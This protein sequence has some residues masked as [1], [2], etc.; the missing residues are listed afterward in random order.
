MAGLLGDHGHRLDRRRPGADHADAQAGEIDR[1]MRPVAGVVDLALEVR[2]ALDIRHPRIRQAAGGEHDVFRRHR[3]AVGGGHRPPIGAFVERHPIDA[4]IELDVAAQ[5]K[6]VGD[7]VGVFQNFRLR[8]V[9][10]APVPFLLQFVGERI[11][12]LHAFDV[13]ARTG[14]AVPVPGAADIAALLIDPHRQ[15]HARAACAAC[16]FRQSPRRPRRH[17]RSRCLRRGFCRKWMARRTSIRAPSD[18][19]RVATSILPAAQK[20]K[21]QKCRPRKAS[22]H[23]CHTRE[24]G[25]SSLAYD[26]R[27]ARITGHPLEPSSGSPKARPG[28]G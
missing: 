4:G 21:R 19:S 6:P 15:S 1:L 12:I 27:T 25:M 22:R 2:E 28:G 10:L 18:F 9:A 11:G 20:R 14:I 26:A 16:T 7:M 8:R 17:H 3:L 5:V 23:S 24:A 13:A